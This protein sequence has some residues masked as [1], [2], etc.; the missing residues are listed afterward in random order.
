MEDESLFKFA[1]NR[2]VVRSSARLSWFVVLIASSKDNERA[3]R[4]R[5]TCELTPKYIKALSVYS[6]TPHS[7]GAHQRADLRSYPPRFCLHFPKQ[8]VSAL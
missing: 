7:R 1:G 6:Q 5:Q 8:V 3:R 4:F 2:D